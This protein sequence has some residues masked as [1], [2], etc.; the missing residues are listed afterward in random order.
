MPRRQ[1]AGSGTQQ[2]NS[3]GIQAAA[4]GRGSLAE[5]EERAAAQAGP[6]HRIEAHVS[7][8]V[9]ALL[10]ERMGERARGDTWRNIRDRLK[11]TRLAQLPS[12]TMT[13]WQVT[14][15]R[16]KARKMLKK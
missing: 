9:L 15:P 11:R 3:A 16:E 5:S 4:E 13:V 14:E 12:G 8:A 10:R 2:P 6:P 1:G 7:I